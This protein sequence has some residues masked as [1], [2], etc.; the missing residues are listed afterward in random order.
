MGKVV[1]CGRRGLTSE[2]LSTIPKKGVLCMKQYCGIHRNAVLCQDLFLYRISI[3]LLRYKSSSNATSRFQQCQLNATAIRSF[4]FQ[5]RH[6]TAFSRFWNHC[7][8]NTLLIPYPERPLFAT[9]CKQ[10]GQS[11]PT[12]TH[13][14]KRYTP[15]QDLRQRLHFSTLN[16]HYLFHHFPARPR[17]VLPQ[18]SV[19]SGSPISFRHSH[20]PGPAPQRHPSTLR[21]R[22]KD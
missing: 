8:I 5:F 11:M 21:R 13:D 18:P 6:N 12:A 7:C 2:S 15:C 14:G 20:P 1:E 17:T 16:P 4:Y 22:R 9:V 19:R 3:V 10:N